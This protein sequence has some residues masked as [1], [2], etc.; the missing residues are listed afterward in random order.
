MGIINK[1]YTFSPSTNASALEVNDNFDTLYNEVNG[2]LSA[3]NLASDSVTTAKIADSN[4]T[5]AKLGSSAVT[6]AKIADEAVTSEK[7]GATVGFY[8]TTTQSMAVGGPNTVT[9]YTEVA[10]YGADFNNTTGVFT[11]PVAGL[12]HFDACMAVSNIAS[13]ADGRW[14]ARITVNGTTKCR[15][16]ADADTTNGD[17]AGNLSLTIPLAASDAVLVAIVQET[18]GSEALD[19]DSFFAGYLVGQV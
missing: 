9:T 16:F 19:S 6:T 13:A 17:P 18:G 10:D 2:N 11:A 8:A 3:A 1:P 7:L 15:S 14:E 4:V 12:Y 5:A